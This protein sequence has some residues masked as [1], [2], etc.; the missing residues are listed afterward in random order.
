[1]NNLVSTGSSTIATRSVVKRIIVIRTASLAGVAQI[2]VATYP[3][4]PALKLRP[5]DRLRML[6]AILTVT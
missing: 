6:G 1:M 4:A 2:V 5:N 3:L